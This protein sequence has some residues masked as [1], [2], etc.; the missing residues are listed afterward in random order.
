M[1]LLHVESMKL[2]TFYGDGIPPYAILSHTWLKDYEEVTFTQ[3]QNPEACRHLAGYR[4]IELLLNQAADEGYEYAW[5]DTCCIDKTSSAELSEAINSMFAWYQRS[6]VCYAYLTDV[7]KTKND[8][9]M[10]SRWWTRAWTLQE[11]LASQDVIFYDNEWNRIGSK[12]ELAAVISKKTGIDKETLREPEQMYLRSV[13]QRMSWASTRQ[14]TRIEDTA[15]S[16]LGIFDINMPLLYGEGKN[17]FVRLQQ[18]I[19]RNSSDQSLFA[20]GFSRERIQD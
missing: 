2:H 4:K 3:V 5:I 7:D 13:A 17:A 9:F 8:N 14:A 15:Y 20:W 12:F 18:E 11:L 16:L 10:E 6:Q 1:R 19:L